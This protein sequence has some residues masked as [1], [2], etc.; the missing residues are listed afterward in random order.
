MAQYDLPSA[1]FAFAWDALRL[2]DIASLPGFEDATE[3]LVGQVIE[4]AGRFATGILLPLNR[5]ADEEGAQLRDGSVAAPPGFREAYRLFCD[6]GWPGLTGTRD[7]G[8]QGLP[9][10]LEYIVTEILASASMAFMQYTALTHGATMVLANHATAELQQVYLPR[11]ISGDWAG[12]MCLTE[13]QA[14]TDLGLIRTRATPRDDG[15]HAIEG[16]KIF[17]TAGEHDLTANIVHLVLARLPDAPPGIAGISLFLVPKYL[18]DDAGNPAQRNAVHCSSIE[19][20]MGMKG[21]PACVMNFDGAEGWLIGEPHK[22]LR[23]MF[24]MM[25]TERLLLSAQGPAAAEVAYQSARTYAEGRAQ[26]RALTGARDPGSLADPLIVHPDVRR[27]LLTMKAHAEGNRLLA[28]WVMKHVDLASHHPDAATRADADALVAL[29]TPIVKVWL[30]E[31]GFEAA[32]LGVQ[33]LGGHG[34]IREWGLEQLVRDVRVVQIYEGANGVQAL[35]L[36]ARKLPMENGALL[37]HLTDPI[38]AFLAENARDDTLVEFLL[39][40]SESLARLRRATAA[41]AELAGDDRDELGAASTDYLKIAGY[42]A[43]TYVWAVAAKAST[44]RLD[45]NPAFHAAKLNTARFFMARI[46]PFA[47]A[48]LAALR[49][50]GRTMAAV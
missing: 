39:P 37:R 4:Q 34:Y 46:L 49:S 32:N 18:P 41:M 9:A 42:A 12:T 43:Q 26:G 47:E 17:I 44:A 36:V 24:T 23:A 6:G 1:D 2:G 28:L 25:N 22:G 3:E 15:R 8:G 19:H 33:T 30:S 11:L 38:E 13:P 29:M 16:T 31:N 50:G 5:G 20:K 45:A 40:L 21:A 10:Y 35:D 7:H 14:G 48:H 27:M